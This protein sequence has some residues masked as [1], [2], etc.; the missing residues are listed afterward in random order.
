MDRVALVIATAGG[1]GYSPVA[2]GTVGSALTVAILWLV[3]FSPRGVIAFCVVVTLVG[4]WAAGRAERVLGGKDPGAIVIDE[5]AG[6]T[7]S[8]LAFPLTLPTLAVGF[9]LFRIFD[10]VKPFPARVSQRARG[11]LGV[12]VDD[13]IAGL[14]S[15]AVLALLRAVFGWQ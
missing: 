14:Y 6:M 4:I 3:P 2:P 11:G 9:V 12:M 8:V 13:L 7:L 5:V 15:L 1:A 10:I